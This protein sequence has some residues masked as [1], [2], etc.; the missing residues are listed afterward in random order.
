RRSRVHAPLPNV[1]DGPL[2]L[3][4]QGIEPPPSLAPRFGL[5]IP[6]PLPVSYECCIMA[7]DALLRG[8]P[9]A[10]FLDKHTGLLPLSLQCP[11]CSR[12]PPRG[13][14]QLLRGDL[15]ERG[16]P[17]RT[18][19]LASV[20]FGAVQRLD[21][22][23]HLITHR[24]P[25]PAVLGP[26]SREHLRK[27]RS[28]RPRGLPSYRSRT[29][30]QLGQLV[31][32]LLVQH[33]NHAALGAHAPVVDDAG[34][35]RLLNRDHGSRP[36][37]AVLDAQISDDDGATVRDRPGQQGQDL[38]LRPRHV[39]TQQLELVHDAIS[40]LTPRGPAAP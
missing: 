19:L 32:R 3:L 6:P 15:G 10:Q 25:Y 36:C 21:Q 7:G 13:D 29:L 31:P 28:P 20:L 16:E 30:G 12:Q 34:D 1:Q 24:P 40:F 26:Q 35:G 14:P 37:D 39:A 38:L 33:P 4:R 2:L 27:P 22:L 8:I 9:R 23:R 11:L 5:L 18:L 17:H